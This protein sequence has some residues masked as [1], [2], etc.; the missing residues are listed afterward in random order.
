VTEAI[1]KIANA[2]GVQP[3]EG[4][5]SHDLK[6]HFIDGNKVILNKETLEQHVEEAEF[7]VNDVFALDVYI[8]TG[9]GKTKEVPVQFPTL[10]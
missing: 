2:Y 9:D 8:T 5:L 4:V 1:Q 3:L 10:V 7:Q 6:K